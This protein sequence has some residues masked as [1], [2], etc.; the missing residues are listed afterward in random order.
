MDIDFIKIFV[1]V[2]TALIGWLIGHYF[3]E[4]RNRINKRREISLDHLISAYRI[5]TQDITHRE[6]NADNRLK[7]ENVVS[8]IQLFGTK[9]QAQI[10]IDIIKE[11]A[12]NRTVD[13]D[14]LIK[15]TS[16]I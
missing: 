15:G 1:T 3:T 11:F 6:W 2:L 12:K 5:L 9:E 13:L 7:F 8:E 10:S 16:K 14:I 4:R